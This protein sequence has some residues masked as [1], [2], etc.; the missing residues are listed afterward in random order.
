M[1]QLRTGFY[2]V[3]PQEKIRIRFP[4]PLEEFLAA[5]PL[6]IIRIPDFEPT[7]LILDIRIEF[8]LCDDALKIVLAGKTEQALSVAL[9]VIAIHQAF[10]VFG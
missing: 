8:A 1:I 3:V 9:N 7:R 5:L 4:L 6:R 10:A 2:A